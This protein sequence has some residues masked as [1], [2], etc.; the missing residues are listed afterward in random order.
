MTG[1]EREQGNDGVIECFHIKTVYQVRVANIHKNPDLY[2]P[3]I[4]I[5]G[6]THLPLVLKAVSLYCIQS[7]G[8]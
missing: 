6:Q 1:T 8:N 5:T 2:A 7:N 3:P 4:E